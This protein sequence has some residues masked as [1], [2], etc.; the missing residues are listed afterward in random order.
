MSNEEQKI[1]D[2][3]V[4]YDDAINGIVKYKQA[5]EELEEAEKKLKKDFKDGKVTSSEYARQMVANK[6]QAKNYRESIRV[7]SKEIQNNMKKEKENEGSL[8]S[9]RAQLSN[10]TKAYDELSRAER[11]GAKGKE[12]QKHINEITK[13][14]KKAEEETQRFYRN[15]GNY[16]QS[17]RDAIAGNNQFAKSLLSIGGSGG[18]GAAALAGA[19]VAGL[20]AG[21]GLLKGAI[22]DN[23]ETAREYEKSVSVLAAILATTKDGVRE[24]TDQAKELGAT[25]I[26]TA[27]EVVDL[28]TE[29]AKL[30]YTLKEITDMTPSI[31]LL[32][33]ATGSNLADAASLTGAVLRMF[34]QDTTHTAE[35]VDKMTASTTKS[36][37]SFS[38]LQNAMSTVG[39]VANAFGFKLEDVLALL[40][41]LAN[42]GFDASS[43]ATA[44]RNIL[45]N[46]ADA[47]GKLAKSL[48][49]P[50]TNLD[51]LID[52]LKSLNDSGIDLAES[53][54]L[55]DKRS[56]SAFNTFLSGTD[57]VINL[58]DELVNADGAAKKMAD[59]MGDNLEGAMKGLSSAWEG[60][61][62]YINRSNG[63][64]RKFIDW[65][66]K[67]VRGVTDLLKALDNHFFGDLSAD[68]FMNRLA[69]KYDDGSYDDNG[70][71]IKKPTKE[72]EEPKKTKNKPKPKKLTKSE[73]NAAERARREQEQ[74]N[75]KEQEEIQ[76]AENL[77]LQI[78]QQGADERRKAV[79]NQYNQQI[80]T[81]K[82]RLK[83]EKNLTGDAQAAMTSQMESLA[84]IRDRKL[85]ELDMKFKAE[86]IEREQKN[87][88]M[89]LT[90]V[91]KGTEEEYQLR[92]TKIQNERQLALDA[93]QAAVVSEEEK[94][95][96]I[97]AINEK[98]NKMFADLENERT[99][100]EVEAVK[101]RYQE[102]ILAAE[103]SGDEMREVDKLRLEMEE[104]QELMEMAQQMEGE[105]IQ[106]FNIRKLQMEKDY[107]T[108]KKAL[109]DKEVEIERVKYQAISSMLGGMG[110]VLEAFGEENEG[111]A[112]A[113]KFLSLAQI[114]VNTGL[115]ISE[116]VKAA[117]GV[118]YPGNLAAI[119]STIATVLANVAT[120]VKT[121]KSAK[122]AE[123]GDVIGAG[124]GTSDSVPA[125]LS[126]GESVLT[127]RATSMFAPALS[128]FNQIGG[129]AP[130]RGGGSGGEAGIDFIASAVEKGMS[131]APAPKVSVEEIDKVSNRK[132]DIDKIIVI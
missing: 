122:F 55:T 82:R 29:L 98:Y 97:W 106:D 24:L 73:Q 104:K 52:G 113:A 39:P 9:L 66:T 101:K 123:G 71:I 35:F 49:K 25:T 128:A 32:A 74:R 10:A 3:T 68:G 120:A 112:K 11:N 58:R 72:T 7:L 15:V 12:L 59:T 107:Q 95:R 100:A 114:A 27:H 111:L 22:S 127:A 42:A 124:T 79:E 64:L 4:R 85:A 26:F 70:N 2:I 19:G 53:L 75:K 34:E 92:Y 126:N 8:K 65:C 108:A 130:I 14:L 31:L 99:Q 36:A 33:Q 94:E 37:L 121:V 47:N 28:Q 118:P 30:G 17:I 63:L 96:N 89:I 1:L 41:Q 125:R 60:L 87:I 40:G 54:E 131:N 43:A 57:T 91:R 132:D 105:S 18:A 84:K 119:A 129:G 5:L 80:D 51:E 21:I 90:T 86:E 67:A 45:L 83:D 102:K 13:E 117:A 93:A 44:T 62:L 46:L 61:N 110:D 16:K 77:M 116:G 76:K 103:T 109:N 50:V 78:V 48:G 88:E 38:Y 56:V 69:E 6:E 20:V 115:A 23:I 81:I